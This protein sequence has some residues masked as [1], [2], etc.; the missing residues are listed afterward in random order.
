[1]PAEECPHLSLTD[2]PSQ[3]LHHWAIIKIEQDSHYFKNA[4]QIYETG[5]AFLVK[6]NIFSKS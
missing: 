2:K 1:M 3:N 6:K 5:T 4:G